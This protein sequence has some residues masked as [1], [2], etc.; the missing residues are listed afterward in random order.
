[1]NERITAPPAC[2]SPDGAPPLRAPTPAAGAQ[3]GRV[4]RDINDSPVHGALEDRAEQTAR[5]IRNDVRTYGWSY[6]EGVS[7]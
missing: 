3:T 6:A 5:H 2:A 1:M 7:W 4:V